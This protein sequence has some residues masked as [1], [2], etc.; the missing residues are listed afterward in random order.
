MELGDQLVRPVDVL[1][2]GDR[3]QEVAR[4]GQAVRADR[5]EVGQAEGAAVVLADVAAAAAVGQL[6][7]EAHAARNDDD[8]LRL[9]VD[10]AE[11]GDE[12]VPALLRHDQHLA[13]GV[14]EGAALHRAVGGVDVGGGAGLR[15]RRR[16]CRPS[17]PGPATKS[18]GAVGHRQRIPAQLV[19]RRR[20]G[21][22]LADDPAGVERLER[23]VHRRRPDPV[24]PGAAVVGARRG[25][26]GA[27]QLL[28]VEAV[29]AALRRVAA[30]RQRAF[31]R[32][33]G[34]LV[35]EAGQVAV[36]VSSSPPSQHAAR[37]SG[38]ARSTGTGP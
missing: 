7:A 19:R 17:S 9:G 38:R 1:V 21:V 14:V 16:R 11:L 4:V 18:V 36:H 31:E 22:E 34:E 28:G 15:L 2:G 32:L 29:G 35:A 26:G 30:D 10:D 23:L 5:A 37:R 6:E 3:R 25:E 27:A 33:G 8:L 20:H 13:V 12:A 24:Q